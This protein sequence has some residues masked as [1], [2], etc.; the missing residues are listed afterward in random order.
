M[1]SKELWD[2]RDAIADGAS[3]AVDE[4]SSWSWAEN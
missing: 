2:N 3:D 1:A 4:I